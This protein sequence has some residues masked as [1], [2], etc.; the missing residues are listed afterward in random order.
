L[1]N[2]P[3]SFV[4]VV[5]EYLRRILGLQRNE[6][7]DKHC[8]MIMIISTLNSTIVGFDPSSSMKYKETKYV[9]SRPTISTRG[10]A[11][12]DDWSNLITLSLCPS[13]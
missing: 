5:Q 9:G 3:T 11:L 7:V 1:S 12:L 6:E 8:K 10:S 4:G 2:I 13:S